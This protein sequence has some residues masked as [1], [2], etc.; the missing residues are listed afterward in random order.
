MTWA[1]WWSVWSTLCCYG[2]ECGDACNLA[3]IAFNKSATQS[4]TSHYGFAERAV[5]GNLDPRYS[6]RS[7]SHTKQEDVAWWQV[8]FGGIYTIEQVSIQNRIQSAWDLADFVI[9]V[10]DT[11]DIGPNSYFLSGRL[12]YNY[13]ETHVPSGELRTLPC[14]NNTVGRYLRISKKMGR[15]MLCEV[16]VDGK[17]KCCLYNGCKQFPTIKQHE[18]QS[19]QDIIQNLKQ[20]RVNGKRCNFRR[21]WIKE[22]G[23]VASGWYWSVWFPDN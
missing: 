22:G 1:L 15:L 23:N 19:V 7:C 12:C 17:P 6:K 9:E 10:S 8:D 13:T 3:N 14:P 18:G 11:T 21:K 2:T 20:M 16:I 5:D 4:S